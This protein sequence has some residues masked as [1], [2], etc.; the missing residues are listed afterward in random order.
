[1]FVSRMNAHTNNAWNILQ[2]GPAPEH[3]TVPGFVNVLAPVSN[4]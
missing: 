3:I 4:R 1:M 2:T